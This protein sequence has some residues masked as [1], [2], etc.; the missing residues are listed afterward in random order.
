M[1]KNFGKVFG[2]TFKNQVNSKSYKITTCLVSLLLF[3]V[4][5]IVF[6]IIAS[7][8]KD[9]KKNEE[10][11]KKTAVEN[12][13]VVN[14]YAPSADYSFLNLLGEENYS[15]KVYKN[16]K[17][18]D[19]AL[20]DVKDGDKTVIYRVICEDKELVATYI[21][22]SKAGISKKDVDNLSG[23]FNRYSNILNIVSVG[24][25]LDKLNQLS[26]PTNS[27][28]RSVT[29]SD[30]EADKLNKE[31]AKE[32]E[33]KNIKMGFKLVLVFMTCMIVYFVVLMYGIA[34][35]GSIVDEKAS[36][37]M[38]TMLISVSP[39]A[40]MLGKFLGIL[41]AGI[42]QILSWVISLILG[43]VVGIKIVDNAFE[44]VEA[45]IFEFV[46]SFGEQGIFTPLNI[47][48]A[49]VALILG[50]SLFASL[51]T[52]AGAISNTKEEATANQGYFVIVLVI[53]FYIVLFG[54]FISAAA[55]GGNPPVWMSLVPFVSSMI[56]PATLSLGIVPLGL[57]ILAIVI[58]IALEIL[59]IF[60]AGR[61]Y[62]MTAFYK[63]NKIT[64]VKLFRMIFTGK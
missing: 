43:F 15:D 9:D 57:G 19:D 56:L 31:H 17:S 48:L 53:A 47:V 23:F 59:L 34:I 28:M 11:L 16:Y 39:Q 46:K 61:L 30:S 49:V 3:L 12:I 27:S 22:P 29:A 41:T 8:S 10:K 38:D 58:M 64:P 13:Y 1:F 62:K 51:S 54:G 25:E 20:M 36:K 52:I 42:L 44:G 55:S 18:V 14:E 60:V 40:L 63:G 45:T 21:L 4:P 7:K 35:T 24:L 6:L 33:L 32:K 50:I 37:L 2:F 26:I 5:V